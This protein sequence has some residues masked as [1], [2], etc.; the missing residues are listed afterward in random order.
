MLVIDASG[1]TR[2]DRLNF[3]KN[4][5]INLLSSLEVR[6]NKTRVG[7]VVYSDTAQLVVKLGDL[8][9]RQVRFSGSV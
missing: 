9:S 5:T 4:M 6:P 8:Y 3:V 1:S 7:I 2:E